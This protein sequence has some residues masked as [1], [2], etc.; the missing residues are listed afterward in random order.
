MPG[1]T[2]DNDGIM[3]G[4]RPRPVP[5][6]HRLA[7]L[8]RL[9]AVVGAVVAAT[10]VVLVG[11]A[12]PAAANGSKPPSTNYRSTVTAVPEGVD[13]RVLGGDA[14]LAVSAEP[15]AEV[16]VRGY[17]GE[18]YLRIDGDGTVWR[19][20]RSPATYLN[21][22]R[23]GEADGAR[24]SPGADSDAQPEWEQVADG[25]QY[26][27]HDHRIHWMSPQPPPK[28]EDATSA[29]DVFDWTVPVR[30]D[31]RE[32]QIRGELR[33]LP[34]DSPL[35]WLLAAGLVAG[36]GLWAARRAPQRTATIAGAAASG[37]AVVVVAVEA[38]Q[39]VAGRGLPAAWYLGVVA[40]GGLLGIGIALWR[41]AAP[42][43]V[44]M[45]AVLGGGGAMLLRVPALWRPVIPGPWD[46]TLAR[47]LT[48]AALAAAVVALVATVLTPPRPEP[49]AGA[50]S[51]SEP[52]E[53]GEPDRR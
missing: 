6:R 9:G 29:V 28:T 52:G 41:G 12:P 24:P 31:G 23:Y 46:A 45:L 32:A 38:S 43:G 40:L 33:W 20:V 30:V 7:A 47:G 11:S 13:A 53:P 15:G 8:A 48:T 50:D 21:E 16:E 34:T 44:V 35:W 49:A 36:G 22:E 51:D 17:E 2:A 26:G 37:L 19:N 5:G 4:M 14:Y 39:H 27:W 18:P 42:E 25:G 10:G 1:R 3:A